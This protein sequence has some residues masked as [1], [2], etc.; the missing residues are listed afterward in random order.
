MCRRNS[1]GDF[2]IFDL[3]EDMRP[4]VGAERLRRHCFYATPQD[5]FKIESQFYEII[6]CLFPLFEVN[7]E[8][9]IAARPHLIADERAKKAIA[10]NTELLEPRLIISQTI[11]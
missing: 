5:V 3:A 6:E 2:D 8:V 4:N 9:N 10:T 11:E 1:A 7:Q